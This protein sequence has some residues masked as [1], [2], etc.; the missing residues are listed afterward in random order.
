MVPGAGAWVE[1]WVPLAVA[2]HVFAISWL[3]HALALV[4]PGYLPVLREKLRRF[5]KCGAK[6]TTSGSAME[7]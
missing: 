3:L 7:R 6:S 4:Y 1:L 5:G 2:A